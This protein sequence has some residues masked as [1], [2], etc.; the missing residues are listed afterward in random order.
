MQDAASLGKHGIVHPLCILSSPSLANYLVVGMLQVQKRKSGVCEG[1]A[2]VQGADIS[3][4]Q[5]R[6]DTF[7]RGHCGWKCDRGCPPR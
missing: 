4:K 7:G 2:E 6:S 5:A 1:A 3:S